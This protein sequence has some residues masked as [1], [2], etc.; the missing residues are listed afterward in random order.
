MHQW[1]LKLWTR[2]LTPTWKPTPSVTGHVNQRG[3]PTHRNRKHLTKKHEKWKRRKRKLQRISKIYTHP[4]TNKPLGEDSPQ[5]KNG[6][7]M[8]PNESTRQLWNT[9]KTTK[10]H[11][12]A[13]R[14]ANNTKA[15][16]MPHHRGVRTKI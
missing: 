8:A 15:M 11:R 3:R 10:R 1:F 4:K 12:G 5:D 14:V 16:Y 6:V 2:S 9:H 7:I 13:S